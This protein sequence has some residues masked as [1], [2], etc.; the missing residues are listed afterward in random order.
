MDALNNFELW[1]RRLRVELKKRLPAEEEEEQ[2]TLARR[3][4]QLWH[5]N[6]FLTTLEGGVRYGM[7]VEGQRASVEAL[8]PAVQP[9]IVSLVPVIETPP[10]GTSLP[11]LE[12]VVDERCGFQ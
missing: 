2:R 3:Y 10:T 9:Q 1:G 12:Y 8:D 7:A 4:G 5:E 6:S 11:P